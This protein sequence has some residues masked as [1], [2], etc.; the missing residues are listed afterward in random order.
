MN[1]VLI[2]SRSLGSGNL[3]IDS[4]IK[5]SGFTI[6]RGP[7]NHDL[8]QLASSLESATAWI[9][10][11]GL[12]TKEHLD[13]APNLKIIARYGVGVEA[14]DLQL[15]KERGIFV[16]NTPGA[17][18]DA[19]AELS[20]GLML[21]ALRHV[22]FG[23]NQV[24]A[25]KWE[26]IPGQELGSLT[27]GVVGFGRIGQGVASKLSGF[28]SKLLAFDPYATKEA[29]KNGVTQ[30]A[31]LE[32]LVQQCDVITLHAPGSEVLLNAETLKIAKPG[33]IIINTAR[34][35][36]VDE[37]ALATALRKRSVGSYAS[38]VLSVENSKQASPLLAEDLK[39]FVTLTPHIGAQTIQAIDKMGSMAWA[40]VKAVLA[41]EPPI[42][43]V[44]IEK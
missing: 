2:T 33:V 31:T 15:A 25:D 3:D 40:N 35:G 14:V 22:A 34:A 28:G 16:T 36:L 42:N 1:H 4:E 12:I 6:S 10:G 39:K 43:P 26:T 32:E 5:S 37:K 9:A 44:E 19:V 29:F 11:T 21:A 24:R 30:V 7:A 23:D 17:N 8:A 18:S 13:L 20:I 27:V 41:G 38:D